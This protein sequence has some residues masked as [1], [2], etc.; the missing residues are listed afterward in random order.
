MLRHVVGAL[1]AGLAGHARDFDQHRDLAVEVQVA[2]DR[3][4]LRGEARDTTQRHVLAGLGGRGFDDFAQRLRL[5]V[6]PVAVHEGMIG[7]DIGDAVER[8]VLADV[9]GDELGQRDELLVAGDEI[10]LRVEF[11]GDAQ[12]GVIGD[13]GHDLSFRGRAA[14]ALLRLQHPLLAQDR[15]RGLGVAVGLLEGL[16]AIAH[17]G[18]RLGTEGGDHGCGDLD[19][20]GHISQS[21]I[22]ASGRAPPTFG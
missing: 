20:L 16:L 17:T 9:M 7:R 10:R 12:G 8:S 11:D 5:V 3:P 1:A 18:A 19:W 15:R 22:V 21:A 13:P 2:P 14:R 4:A 6:V